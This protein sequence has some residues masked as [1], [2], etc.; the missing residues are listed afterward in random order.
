LTGVKHRSTSGEFVR[1]ALVGLASNGV[2]FVMYL[3]ATSLGV[4]HKLA[5]TL[6]YGL[7]VAQTFVL[8]R[9]WSFADRG[10]VGPALLRYVSI[11]FAGYVI[12]MIALVSLVD[13]AG[14][15]H[16][17][18]QGGMIVVVAIMLFALQKW[19]VF[20]NDGGVRT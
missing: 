17:W 14:F 12:N 8:N 4:G 9:S 16:V 6:A 7:G 15:P 13:Y 3:V 5:A 19:W 1:Y 18:V 10:L 11:Y 20:R 2:V